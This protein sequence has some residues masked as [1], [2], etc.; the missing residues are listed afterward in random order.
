[1]E[2]A[3]PLAFWASARERTRKPSAVSGVLE[4]V[5]LPFGPKHGGFSSEVQ[6]TASA[7]EI[8]VAD[9]ESSGGWT[10]RGM[11]EISP[12]SRQPESCAA[13]KEGSKKKRAKL[14]AFCGTGSPSCSFPSRQSRNCSRGLFRFSQRRPRKWDCPPGP[15]GTGT[16]FGPQWAE[17]RAS[18][19]PLNGYQ[20]LLWPG[21]NPAQTNHFWCIA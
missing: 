19:K 3:N 12:H 5:E 20:F 16:F 4:G 17:K 18:P 13:V 8:Q 9:R 7:E 11:I 21:F 2:P 6:Y 1:M 15:K 14:L 10:A